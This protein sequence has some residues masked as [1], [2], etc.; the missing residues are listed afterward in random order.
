MSAR[1]LMIP[2]GCAFAKQPRRAS[3]WVISE[4]GFCYLWTFFNSKG[5]THIKYFFI[6]LYFQVTSSGGWVLK[7][8]GTY[9]MV[10]NRTESYQRSSSRTSTILKSSLAFLLRKML[11]E[12][13]T[14]IKAETLKE[15]GRANF[16][17]LTGRRKYSSIYRYP[18]QVLWES[19]VNTSGSSN[20]MWATSTCCC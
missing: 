6:Y 10:T 17:Y 4:R 7:V 20:P 13:L 3:S 16:Q 2:T 18:T 5:A 8:M 14:T 15:G 11:L 9:R 12:T 19:V 1:V